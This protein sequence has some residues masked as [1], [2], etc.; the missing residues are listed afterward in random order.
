MDDD[1]L[2]SEAAG[3]SSHAPLCGDDERERSEP[4]GIDPDDPARYE[5]R[6]TLLRCEL[7]LLSS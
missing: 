6:S 1:T 2:G 3:A 5:R 4:K 7:E